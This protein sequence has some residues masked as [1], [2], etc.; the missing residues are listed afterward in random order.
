[1][2]VKLGNHIQEY[3]VRNKSLQ[4]DK[5]FSVTNTEGFI[6]SSEYF[7]KEVFSKDLSTYK[8]VKKGMI[9]YNP[10]RINVGSVANLDNEDEVIISPLYVVFKVDDSLDARF[11]TY[12]LKSSIGNQQIRNLT[13]GSV[14][15]SLK[16]NAL[17]K[18]VIPRLDIEKQREVVKILEKVE[19]LISLRKQE[20]EQLD[21]L[22]KSQF[23]EMFGN[24]KFS[25]SKLGD[26]CS[27][28]TD[29]THKTPNYLKDGVTFISAKNVVNGKIDLSDVKYI[30]QEEFE[31]IQ[32]RCQTE[33]GDILL[34]KSGSLGA[35]VMLDINI[36]LGLF[37]SLAVIK[38]PRDL[39]LGEFLCEQL[40][41]DNIQ[42][43]FK[44]GTKGVA[45]K[46]L[47][48][49][50]IK[51]VEIIVPPI[52]LQNQFAIFIQQVEKQK[53]KV[54]QSLNETQL[55]FDSLMQQYF[56]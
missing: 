20:I 30:S 26:L 17:E 8:I 2:R 40:K 41:S 51:D 24:G 15:D 10:S 37:E 45:I 14:R 49:N 43:Q 7:S 27:K 39:L 4:C 35:P 18:I 53:F 5:V 54:Q 31:V 55:L 42:R 6:P 48:L 44:T 11:I 29:G 12:F 1:M 36:P 22:V 3:S 32:K 52:E 9:A 25:K 13:T 34:T 23:I 33:M 50:V 19:E 47:H 16:Y 56:G 21:E 28:I 38:Y 46:H